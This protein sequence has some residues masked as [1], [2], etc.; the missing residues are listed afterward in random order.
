MQIFPGGR[1][2]A[3]RVS[4]F[5]SSHL[6]EVCGQP[7]SSKTQR[8]GQGRGFSGTDSQDLLLQGRKERV[9]KGPMNLPA[10][11][12]VQ[13]GFPTG[14]AHSRRPVSA[15][16]PPPRR[17]LPAQAQAAC[18][19]QGPHTPKAS[20]GLQ[21]FARAAPALLLSFHV[22]SHFHRQENGGSETLSEVNS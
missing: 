1:E 14:P 11:E 9:K 13:A 15:S 18:G 12:W 5:H 17:L 22:S 4:G 19:F 2:R 10:S 6:W 3:G 8:K 20:H 16:T 21:S 7:T